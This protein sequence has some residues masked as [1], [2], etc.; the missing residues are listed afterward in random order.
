[1][2]EKSMLEAVKNCLGQRPKVQIAFS[3]ASN[4]FIYLLLTPHPVGSPPIG[5]AGRT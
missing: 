2:S 5:G 4:N 3:L 1:M